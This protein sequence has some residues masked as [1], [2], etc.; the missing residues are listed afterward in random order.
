[1]KRKKPL[2]F[3]LVIL[4]V[5]VFL[6]IIP[7]CKSTCKTPSDKEEGSGVKYVAHRGY[8][9][10]YVDNSEDAFLAAAA[11]GFYGIE[12]DIR[13]T[14]DGYFVCNHDAS[15]EYYNGTEKKISSTKRADLLASPIKNNKTSQDVYLC[16]FEK[17]LQACKS[18]NKTAVIEIKDWFDEDDIQEILKIVDAEYDRKNVMFISFIFLSLLYVKE[19]DPTI[20]L[21]Y[22][23]Q[24]EN[25]QTF[26]RCLSEK[27]S[28]DVKQTIL[29]EE[30]VKQFH[31]AGLKV[32]VWTI[33]TES[34][35]RTVTELG[36]DFVT[37]DL[38]CEY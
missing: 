4:A 7:G 2:L 15:V 27:I 29:T 18:G 6:G 23:S 30:L 19:A 20:P 16:T 12:T 3:M 14:K 13:K 38:F 25:D 9:Q 11:K 28:I 21:Q 37:T 1:M 34:D 17:Y 31:D 26:E 33:N 8:S 35:L 32:N 10:K 5:A 22:L 24:T 36:V